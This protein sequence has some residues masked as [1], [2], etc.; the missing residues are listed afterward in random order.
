MYSEE[1]VKKMIQNA[2]SSGDM[3]DV[4]VFENIVDKD[5]HARFIE[6][7]IETPYIPQGVNKTYGKWSLSGSHFLIVLG[8]SI[9]NGVVFNN[10]VQ[11]AVLDIPD[12]IKEKIIPLWND[13]YVDSNGFRCWGDDWSTQDLRI[14]LVKT[15]DNNIVLYT[16]ASTT[17]TAKRNC[18]IA[19]D[20]LIDNE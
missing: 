5:G 20:L 11:V 18:R 7:D 10:G 1:Q 12:W 6:G 14:N 4:K 15:N 13:V 9:E 17:F 19:F 16:G 8:L 3:K 2:L